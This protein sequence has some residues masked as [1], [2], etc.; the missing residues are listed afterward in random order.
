MSPFSI[1]VE[2]VAD[3]DVGAVLTLLGEAGFARPLIERHS[4]NGSS[5]GPA[6]PH[7][8]GSADLPADWRVLRERPRE[9]YQWSKRRDEYAP[10]RVFAHDETG[11][12]ALT[13]F[14]AQKPWLDLQLL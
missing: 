14:H 6:G 11:E 5:P 2:N 9:T 3:E 1:T 10:Y 13:Y 4:S 8:V 12:V 7:P